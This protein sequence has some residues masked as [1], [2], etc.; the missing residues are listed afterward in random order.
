MVG[1]YL[2]HHDPVGVLQFESWPLVLLTDESLDMGLELPLGGPHPGDEH[3]LPQGDLNVVHT[4]VPGLV[5]VGVD[6]A[7]ALPLFQGLAVRHL[8][9]LGPVVGHGVLPVHLE[10]DRDPLPGIFRPINLGETFK[11]DGIFQV[12][13]GGGVDVGRG[14][15][16]LLFQFLPGAAVLGDPVGHVLVGL[17]APRVEPDG[18]DGEHLARLHGF[19]ENREDQAGDRLPAFLVAIVHRHN[20][21]AVKELDPIL[22]ECLGAVG[23]ADPDIPCLLLGQH[24]V[25]LALGDDHRGARGSCRQPVRPVQ[26]GG[27]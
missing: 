9:L 19:L 1:E 27:A 23:R 18:L 12:D 21:V 6:V 25:E 13:G 3:P 2:P 8:D 11:L 20:M 16:D 15:S 14:V 26:P 17:V 22:L 10:V 5:G 7:V 24:A 4:P